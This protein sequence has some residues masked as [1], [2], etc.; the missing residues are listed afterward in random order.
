MKKLVAA[1]IFL[2]VSCHPKVKVIE[3]SRV[4]LD[5]ETIVN[6]RCADFDQQFGED[7]TKKELNSRNDIDNF[8]ALLSRLKKDHTGRNVDTRAKILIKCES[9]TDTICADRFELMYKQNAF[10]M[11][12][13]LRSFLWDTVR[14]K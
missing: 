2:L 11:S 14:V 3:I 1:I 6:I 13:E 4:D 12:D 10:D 7:M 5:I 9:F 8:I